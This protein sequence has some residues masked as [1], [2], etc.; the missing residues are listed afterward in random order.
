LAE[1]D[2]DAEIELTLDELQVYIII[3]VTLS[4]LEQTNAADV[5]YAA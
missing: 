1:E 4:I 2:F 3:D 5:S